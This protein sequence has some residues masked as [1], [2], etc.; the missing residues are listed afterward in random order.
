[1]T[2]PQ[3]NPLQQWPVAAFTL[4]YMAAAVVAATIGRNFEFVFYIAVMVILIAIVSALYLRVGLSTA[5]MWALSIWGLAHMAGGLVPVPES[6][7]INGEIRVLYSLWLVPG[8]LK[9]DHVVHAYGFAVTTW[10]CWQVLHNGAARAGQTIRP[11][12]G[13]MVLCGAGGLGFGALNEVVEFF[14]TLLMPSTNVGGYINT[15]WDLVANT[16]GCVIAATLIWLHG[17]NAAYATA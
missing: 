9:Y 14:A 12:F 7:P 4:A 5:A 17:R 6:W 16:I 13:I 15:G 10:L 8:K 11:T 2:H 3:P 1:M